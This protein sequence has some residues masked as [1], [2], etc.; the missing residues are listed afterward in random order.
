MSEW[1]TYTIFWKPDMAT[2]LVDSEVVATAYHPPTFNEF[3]SN[4]WERVP[5]TP[6]NWR[7]VDDSDTE[8][9]VNTTIQ[10]DY[11]HVFTTEEEMSRMFY[12][13]ERKIVE[14]TNLLPSWVNMYANSVFWNATE[15]RVNGDYY[16]SVRQLSK[17]FTLCEIPELINHAQDSLK[18]I[19]NLGYRITKGKSAFESSI[20]QWE[21]RT[22]FE[23]NTEAWSRDLF[24]L[25]GGILLERE[26][27][28][29]FRNIIAWHDVI[30]QDMF[31]TVNHTIKCLELAGEDTEILEC[32]F[33]AAQGAWEAGRFKVVSEGMK[34]SFDHL[35]AKNLLDMI[36][37]NCRVISQEVYQLEGMFSQAE[38][39]IKKAR[40]A[41]MDTEK[42]ETYLQVAEDFWEDCDHAMAQTYLEGILETRLPEPILLPILGL[43]LL[44]ALQRRINQA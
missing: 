13:A 38:E 19:E 26:S 37:A 8:H 18:A 40:K 16:N 41:G 10:I 24:G 15:S 3:T 4:I 28:I 31:Q 21:N 44:S 6:F 42:M 36:L 25:S 30:G 27:V 35:K 43:I 2:F 12:D 22:T 39:H 9:K 7:V 34:P 5:R 29:P 17:I 11:I 1:H 14:M 32:Y 33:S 20:L 23:H